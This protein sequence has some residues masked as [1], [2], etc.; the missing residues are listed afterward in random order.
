MLTYSNSNPLSIPIRML[1]IVPPLFSQY[2]FVRPSTLLPLLIPPFAFV[3]F[4][5]TPPSKTLPPNVPSLQTYPPSKRTLPPNAFAQF[6]LSPPPSPLPPYAFLRFGWPP[7]PPLTY[8][9]S[10]NYPCPL[11]NNAY[12]Q[13]GPVVLQRVE[14]HLKLSNTVQLCTSE[15]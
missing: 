6:L 9:Y 13:L 4:L 7:I 11:P 1:F 14:F 2:A 15:L 8:S 12:G 5:L 10:F 3:Q